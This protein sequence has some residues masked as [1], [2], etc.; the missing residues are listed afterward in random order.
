MVRSS[1]VRGNLQ[2]RRGLSVSNFLHQNRFY[3]CADP[4]LET[5]HFPIPIATPHM[6]SH[7]VLMAGMDSCNV[8]PPWTVNGEPVVRQVI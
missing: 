7:V 6:F 1:A 4:Y 3:H 8:L 5:R 2:R